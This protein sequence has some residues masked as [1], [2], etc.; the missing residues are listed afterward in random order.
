MQA[1]GWK[2][3]VRIAAWLPRYRSRLLLGDILAGLVVAAL[4]VPQSL[5]YAGIAGVPVVVGLYAM[6]AAP[7]P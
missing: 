2:G 3:Y 4:A 6:P 1:V 7:S 5:G